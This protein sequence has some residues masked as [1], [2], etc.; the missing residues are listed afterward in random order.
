M[1]TQ[2]RLASDNHIAFIMHRYMDG[3]SFNTAMGLQWNI[4]DC[5]F[6]HWLITIQHIDIIV[7]ICWDDGLSH[8]VCIDIKCFLIEMFRI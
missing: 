3:I 7:R 1:H 4:F 2:R 6:H 8:H 5:I